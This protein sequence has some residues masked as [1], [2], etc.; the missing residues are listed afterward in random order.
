MDGKEELKIKY[1]LGE[2][3]IWCKNKCID[4][5]KYYRLIIAF[6][7]YTFPYI[8][9]LVIIFITKNKKSFIFTK[10]LISILYILEIYSSFRVGCTDPGI[11]PKQYVSYVKKKPER[12]NVI[13]GHLITLKYCISCDIFRPPRSSHCSK[14]DNCVQKF[15]HHCDWIGTCVGIRN[16]KFFYL[17][18]FCLT[19]DDIYQ[20]VFCLYIL[21]SHIKEEK[22]ND[23]KFFTI[24]I[25]ISIIVLYDLLFINL[26]LCKLY[27]SHTYFCINNL[28]YYECH[29]KKFNEIPF[30]NPYKQN[31]YNNFR[32]IFCKSAR[33]TIFFDEPFNMIDNNFHD[34][35]NVHHTNENIKIANKLLKRENKI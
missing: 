19:I 4:G 29:K 15:D 31:F 20:I 16:Y 27:M 14:C 21:F 7:S 11:L 26:F 33:K 9:I 5:K 8:G 35:I 2:N 1:D 30:F 18:I 12:K 13:R 32:Q 23:W 17:L 28:S 3:V 10:I 22:S 25:S 24:I 6:I 34:Q